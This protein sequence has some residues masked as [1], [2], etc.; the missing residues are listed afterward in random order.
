MKPQHDPI[1]K[2]IIVV[3]A[4]QR[5][6]AAVLLVHN[7]LRINAG[8]SAQHTKKL[9]IALLALRDDFKKFLLNGSI[10]P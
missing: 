9:I 10:Y 2:P 6:I 8:S 5:Q 4:V 1:S 3:W 7:T